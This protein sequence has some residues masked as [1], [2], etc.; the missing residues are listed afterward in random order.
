MKKYLL[1]SL[2]LL[3]S[4]CGSTEGFTP[5]GRGSLSEDLA[6]EDTAAWAGLKICSRL[7]FFGVEW[8]ER[9]TWDERD[10][11]ALALNITGSF[12][13]AKG[14]GNLT[15]NFDGQGLSM[16]L[17]QQNLGQGS[18]Q[19]MWIDMRSQHAEVLGSVLSKKN[20]E[21]VIRMLNLWSSGSVMASAL[22]LEEMGYSAL[23][24]PQ[25]IARD[26]GGGSQKVMQAALALSARNQKSVD[27]AKANLYTG[28]KFKADW[29]SQLKALAL[30]AEYRTLQL[31][32][33]ERLHFKALD[34]M[35]SFSFDSIK[36]YLF[37][38]DIVVQNGGIPQSVAKDYRDWLA[39]NLK[40]SEVARLSK[41][42]ELRLRLVRQQYRTDVR[43]R[44]ETI[45]K[46]YGTVH[47]AKRNLEK[48]FCYDY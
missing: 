33:A 35:E 10:P 21:N 37:F 46:G 22:N 27:W 11:F 2:I 24:D 9:V 36:S 32:R 14:W 1:T 19:P 20:F 42:L 28:S 5:E 23:D 29:S 39:R 41:L 44:K 3:L 38:F 18:L 8:S 34:L 26:F 12:E 47:G 15:N 30:T 25:E 31:Q 40:S 7:D 48:E 45:L 4:A 17:L 16:G 13:G 43:R 6:E